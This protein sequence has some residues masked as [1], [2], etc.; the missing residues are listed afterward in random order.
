LGSNHR[1]FARLGFADEDEE[2]ARLRIFAELLA[3]R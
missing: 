3:R 2:R 1:I